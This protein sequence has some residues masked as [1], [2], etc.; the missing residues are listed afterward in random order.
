MLTKSINLN[1]HWSYLSPCN[2]VLSSKCAYNYTLRILC[3]YPCVYCV[4]IPLCYVYYVYCVYMPLCYVYYVYCVYMPLCYVYYVYC[5]YMPLCY[6][7]YVYCVY[8]MYTLVLLLL[9]DYAILLSL[10]TVSQYLYTSI[11]VFFTFQF[12]YFLISSS[13]FFT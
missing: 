9:L 11:F 10:P 1:Y 7:Y 3:T 2:C 5:V 13:F 12:Y 6:V 4:Y 8:R